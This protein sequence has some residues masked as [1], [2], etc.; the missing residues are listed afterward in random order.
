[1]NRLYQHDKKKKNKILCSEPCFACF[2]AVSNVDYLFQGDLLIKMRQLTQG[3]G[4]LLLPT[5][6]IK[7]V[8]IDCFM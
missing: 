5:A 1:M 4:G 3:A 2:L 7:T 6:T 8:S